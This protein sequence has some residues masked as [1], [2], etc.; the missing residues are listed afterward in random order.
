MASM[1]AG[2][3]QLNFAAT[4]VVAA[5]LTACAAPPPPPEVVADQVPEV[6]VT[7][8]DY[9]FAAPA[10][11]LGRVIINF[12]NKGAVNHEFI[13]AQVAS[14]VE[15]ADILDAF[16]NSESREG[17]FDAFG[18]VIFADAGETSWGSLT[19]DIEAGRT[20]VLF[21]GFRD[22]PD[23]EQHFNLGMVT[24]FVAGAQ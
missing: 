5:A 17:M 13:I 9:A 21:C 24:S 4:L 8:V 11:P 10:M 19:V 12:E 2:R 16:K 6:L 23:A 1:N 7:G 20:Y 14:G 22:E 3:T 18:G 15:V